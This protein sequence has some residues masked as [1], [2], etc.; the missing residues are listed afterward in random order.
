MYTKAQILHL[1]VE[2]Y[3]QLELESVAHHEYIAGQVYATVANSENSKIITGNILTRLR[4]HLLGT[5]CRVFSSDMKVKIEALDVFYH[6]DV[7]VTCD[8]LDREKLFKINPCLIVEVIS[9]ETERIHRNE[10]LLNYQQI[11]SLQEYVLISESEK[12]VDIYRKY[13]HQTWFL[14]QYFTTD[15]IKLSSVGLEMAIAEIYEDI[16]F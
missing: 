9:P 3:L 15:I 12:K 7:C 5:S 16:E 11:K 14:E 2:E 8:P 6:P 1:T 4:T 13:N 10:K